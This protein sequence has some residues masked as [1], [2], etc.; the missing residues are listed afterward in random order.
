VTCLPQDAACTATSGGVL[1]PCLKKRLIGSPIRHP[2]SFGFNR[3]RRRTHRVTGSSCKQPAAVSSNPPPFQATR[4]LRLHR[5][6]MH[7]PG[8][9]DVE[10]RKKLLQGLL[11]GWHI[12][13][14]L[15]RRRPRVEW[16]Y[17]L[18]TAPEIH[19]AS[20]FQT[21]TPSALRSNAILR[22]GNRK[23]RRH[24]HARRNSMQ[25]SVCTERCG[26]TVNRTGRASKFQNGKLFR[27]AK[28]SARRGT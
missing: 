12:A 20:I 2:L 7:G 16:L 4:R 21:V 6:L 22:A 3:R 9:L 24:P 19:M 13:R 26:G 8:Q 28:P 1:D 10:A 18:R 23:P 14:S 11:R 15:A 27:P 5:P 17:C 25:N